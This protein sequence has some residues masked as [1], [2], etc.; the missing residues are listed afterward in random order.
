MRVIAGQW[1]GRRLA[2]PAGE[3]LR[4][5]TG[6][7]REALCSLLGER[8]RGAEVVDLCCGAGCLGIEA[9]SRGAARAHFVDVATPAIQATRRNLA[10]CGAE[11]ER[12]AVWRE[13][14]VRWLQR[15]PERLGG[16]TL[17]VLAD[18][19]Y[20]LDLAARIVAELLALP[21]RVP[22]IVA[23]VEHAAGAVTVPA[24]AARFRV[25]VRRYGKTELTILEV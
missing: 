23:A 14:A 19:P 2:A 18:P 17:I 15:A 7:V 5:T 4:P 25:R 1:R 11:P 22:L 21:E 3:A 24:P 8:L 12:Y 16:G 13:D 6:R 9:L 20:G 10:L